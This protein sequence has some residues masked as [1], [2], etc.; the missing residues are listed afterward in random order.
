MAAPRFTNQALP[1]SFGIINAIN[2]LHG[3]FQSNPQLY[4]LAISS[5][6]SF[7]SPST[8]L[9]PI[10][11]RSKSDPHLGIL[12]VF[13]LLL[14]GTKVFAHHGVH[15]A[16]SGGMQENEAWAGSL[17]GRFRPRARLLE[18]GPRCLGGF[19]QELCF[20]TSHVPWVSPFPASNNFKYILL[21]FSAV[22]KLCI[23]TEVCHA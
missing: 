8:D 20:S 5:T 7:Q 9:N 19:S 22:V 23:L 15:A 12:S 1:N 17:R 4:P 6:K 21:Q 16:V 14:P 18:S 13:F 10:F 2:A 11:I 3:R